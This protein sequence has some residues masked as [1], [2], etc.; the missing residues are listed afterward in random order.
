MR[1][2]E[3]S[4][5]KT[6][7]A[8]FTGTLPG[9]K[10]CFVTDYLLENFPDEEIKAV[11]AHEIGHLKNRDLLVK[12]FVSISFFGI[13]FLI[14]WILSISGISFEVSESFPSFVFI[15]PIIYFFHRI[16][17]QGVLS[18]FQEYKADKYAAE[19]VGRESVIN[20]LRRLGEVNV[21]K[22]ET[23]LLYNLLTFHPSIDERIRKVKEGE[24]PR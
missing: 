13:L 14:S 19:T 8:A 22:K 5:T 7:N 9:A 15:F 2:E 11:L 20:A 17:V 21:Q 6:A 3:G 1:V 4:S 12:I 10:Y 18:Q 24:N 16:V 23:G